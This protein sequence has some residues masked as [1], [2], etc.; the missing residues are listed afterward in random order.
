V[1]A[2]AVSTAS[3]AS[4]RVCASGC[5]Y[6]TLQP[7]IDAA[8]PG[9]TILLKAGETFVGPFI[10]RAKPTS[11]S[12]IT[13][14]SDASDSLLPA[15]GV[16]LV[17][18]GRPGANTSRSLLP[19]LIGQGGALKTTPVI[20]TATG[21]HH[22]ML[23]FLEIDG[24]ANLGF[25]TL[26][27]LGD[28]TTATA[29]HD[30]VID[31][32]YAH[33][34]F[35][36]GMKRGISLNSERTDI[37][38]SYISD[39]K[40]VN[41]DS[42]AIAGYNGKGPFRIINNYLEG[43]G[44]NIIFGG[45]DPAVSGLIPSDIEVRGNHMFKPLAWQ[46]AILA[47]PAS[48]KAS[49][50]T[51]GSLAAGTHYF[52]VVALMDTDTRTAVSVPSAEV[53]ASVSA[54]GAVSLTWSAVGGAN[55]Y[56]IYRGTSA[57]GESKYL[58]TS[59]ATTSFKY[60]GASES[61]GTPAT[62][63]TQWTVKNIFELKNAQRVVV[64]GNLFENIW[65]AG[66]YG[67]ALVL[68]PRNQYGSATWV[69]LRDI[70]I[71]NNIVRHASGVLQLSGYD[72]THPSQQTQRVT[73]RN[74]LFYDIDPKKWGGNAKAYLIGEGPA[75]IVLDRNTLIHT[76]T[77]VV[78]AYGTQTIT[79]FVYTNNISLHGTY[80][81]MG[82]GG[83]PGQYSIDKYFPSSTIKNNVLA[84]GSASVYPTPNSFPTVAQ[85]NASFVDLAGGDYRILSTSVFYTAGAGGTVPGADLGAVYTAVNNGTLTVTPP[86]GTV[87]PPPPPPPTNAA[88][89]AKPGGPYTGV[90]GTAITVDG[91]GSS[92]SDGGIA[93][94]RW[95]WG[96]EIVVNA[97]DVPASGIVG[98]KWVREQASGA[99]D[100]VALHNPN[101][102]AAKLASALAA[103]ASYVDVKFYAAAG[104]P[105]H[106]WFRM[107]AEGD[108]YSNDSMFVQ[109]S[110][111]VDGQGAA[112]NRIGTTAAGIVIL[113]DGRDLGVSG[114]GWNDEAYGALADPVYFATTGV[115]TIRVQQREDG[116]MWDQMVLSAAKYLKASPG[117]PRVDTTIVTEPDAST[118]V[119]SHAYGVAGTYP[120]V[121]TV[122]DTAGAS[123]SAM[124]TAAIGGGS[125]GLVARAGGP[126]A[127]A[128]GTP[129][130]FDASQS[131]VP[132]GT[133]P[134]YQWA[135]GD[136]IVL[137][138]SLLT[139]IGT[140]WRKVTDAS[141]AGGAAVEN[142]NAS[143]ARISQA[144]ASPASYVEATFRA[145]AKVPYRLWLRMRAAGDSYSNDSV[146]VQFSGTVTSA[147]S[148]ATRIGTTG[149]LAV[150][151][152]EGNGAGVQGWGWADAG[153]GTL[154]APIY[155]NADGVQTI[156][157]QQRE[158]GPRIDQVVISAGD[159]ASSAPGA[160][161]SDSTVV[162]V[163]GPD[164]IGET[165][166]HAY[167][168]AGAYPVTLTLKAG[169]SAATDETTATIK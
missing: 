79:G 99:A 17:P 93:S 114:W 128:A 3:A 141:A 11:T 8:A 84:G 146:Y 157:I 37:L 60:T 151:L 94:Y 127:G 45:S 95:T 156:R 163:F 35:Y 20:R 121:L 54:S 139:P 19:R 7:A 142:P 113:E 33:G 135:F 86:S 105:Y 18:S 116:I 49:A 71:S 123:A 58:T 90:P 57:G 64:D 162:P 44:E 50:T 166:A 31:R 28:D 85:W 129:V 124:T 150:L 132:S 53:S 32:V 152:E 43:A 34:D 52:K 42:Q 118:M 48:P 89:V 117:L 76:N 109:F 97:A 2:T 126:Y 67:Y 14:R 108:S 6:A 27:A 159:F 133:T 83:R 167:R 5:A 77:S 61:S 122:T 158:D 153:Y 41:A 74:N 98:S 112:I 137:G 39:I 75:D 119:A 148:A 96:D 168:V 144:S 92:D 36:K 12:W 143:Q 55:R 72:A 23:Q 91:S 22:Y 73:L 161:T 4:L 160:T 88:P 149:A 120:V 154:A 101:A 47:A 63:G 104:V 65:Q 24:V 10:L 26:I 1:L 100:G 169:S 40:A 80:G 46:G 16:R 103:P 62:A 51:S 25:E 106:L 145:A 125:T 56:R 81:I 21:A 9:D 164:A 30:I 136:D 134:T 78:Y 155:F 147:G 59:S 102:N 110:G 131:T 138:S 38:N 70:T 69:R 82:E 130:A 115:Q 87:T 68:T 66:Q 15:A 140:R 165:A 111:A 13:I 29:P 107:R